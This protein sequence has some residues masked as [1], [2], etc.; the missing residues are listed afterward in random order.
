MELP[1]PFAALAEKLSRRRARRT[2]SGL[3]FA[4]ADR[5]DALRPDH[6]DAVS[7]EASVFL[8]RDFL[9]ALEENRPA[10]MT[11]RYAI[12]YRGSTPAAIFLTQAVEVS[13]AQFGVAEEALSPADRDLLGL[14]KVTRKAL[15]KVTRRLMVCGNLFTYGHHGV[16]FAPGED[17]AE[18]WPVVAEGLYRLRRAD[19]LQGRVDYQVVKD[20]P[21]DREDPATALA[22]YS[23][24]PLAVDPN[25]VL[26]LDPSWEDFDGYLAALTKKYRKAARTAAKKVEKA[27]A[28]V[29][30]LADLAAHGARVHELYR[31]VASRSEFRLVELGEGFFASLADRLGPERFAAPA[32]WRGDE[33]LGYVTVVRDGETAVGYYLG[34]DYEAN[35]EMPVY[36]RLLYAVVEQAIAWGCRRISYGGTALEAKAR[37]GAEAEPTVA[38]VRHRLPLLNVLVRRALSGV[39]HPEPPDR[40]PFKERP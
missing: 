24:R 1:K 27:G 31:A 12:A 34:V 32:I 37:V 16:A 29:E 36:H 35:A 33:L 19:R 40:N 6:W 3:D 17:P 23:Y 8:S 26:T 2:P 7:A 10:G 4:F 18:M 38:W 13:P 25:M 39:P 15:A 9:G 5:L 14:R 22:R 20:L 30:P 21:A 11:P 28:R